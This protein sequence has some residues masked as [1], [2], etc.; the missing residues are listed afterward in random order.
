MKTTVARGYRVQSN[1]GL[2]GLEFE[3]DAA[4][5][6]KYTRFT[7]RQVLQCMKDRNIV[8]LGDSMVRG[9]VS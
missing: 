9:F 4:M 1:D 8:F 2:G 3:E 6:C 7:R 5:G